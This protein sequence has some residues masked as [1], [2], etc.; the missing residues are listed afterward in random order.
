M[1]AGFRLAPVYPQGEDAGLKTGATKEKSPTVA[2]CPIL[3]VAKDGDFQASNI[4]PRA[5]SKVHRRTSTISLDI[6]L[7]STKGPHRLSRPQ[8]SY[9]P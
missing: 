3:C 6:L 1:D 5:S 7:A 2:G 9:A 4:Q 8:R